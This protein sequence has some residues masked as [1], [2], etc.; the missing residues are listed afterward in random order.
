MR[1]VRNISRTVS[2]FKKF[3]GFLYIGCI[4]PIFGFTLR[5]AYSCFIHWHMI[6]LFVG[7]WGQTRTVIALRVKETYHLSTHPGFVSIGE[8]YG[9]RTRINGIT[10]R[11]VNRYTNNSINLVGVQGFEPWTPWSQTRCATRLRH[12][13]N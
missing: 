3:F 2:L 10:I 13:P 9:N 8:S 12:T 11:G 4:H 6:F 5:C 7:T 1:Q